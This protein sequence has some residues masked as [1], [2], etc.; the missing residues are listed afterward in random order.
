MFTG[1]IKSQAV[2][3]NRKKL[4][5]GL[6]LSFQTLGKNSRFERGESIA[7]D[8]TCLTVAAFLGKNFSADVIPETLSS[9]TLG[10]FTV[11]KRVNIER[12]LRIGE[13][14]GGHW[15]TGHVDGVGLI[16]K[17][18]RRGENFRLH[19][20]APADII[21]RLVSK[22]SIAIDGVSFTLQEI[23]KHSF[24]VGVTPHTYRATTLQ[25]KRAGDSV[26]LEVD[27]LSKL[28]QHFVKDA[29]FSSLNK[30]ELRRQGF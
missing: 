2:L 13:A 7:V 4:K 11:G 24:A 19:I 29:S 3:R 16:R 10:N 25:W 30:R 17:I 8:G 1:I 28:V 6:R 5:K 23:Q 15:I 21:R 12:A 27:L 9:T 20:K 22:G 14:L 26:N 18:E